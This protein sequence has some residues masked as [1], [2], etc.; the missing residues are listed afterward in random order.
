MGNQHQRTNT[1]IFTA[2]LLEFS[3]YNNPTKFNM[4]KCCEFKGK[5][6]SKVEST[7]LYLFYMLEIKRMSGQSL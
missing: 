5:Q 6:A 1:V 4:L 3:L 2:N 7:S